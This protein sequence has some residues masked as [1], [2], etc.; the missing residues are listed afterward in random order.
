MDILKESRGTKAV[1]FG[2]KFLQV[3]DRISKESAKL[4]SFL[5]V[6]WIS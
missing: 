1:R 4:S 5:I 3:V 2:A 6:I